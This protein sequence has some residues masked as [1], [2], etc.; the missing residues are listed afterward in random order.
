MVALF[1]GSAM[2]FVLRSDG[3]CFKLVGEIWVPDMM[4]GE[5]YKGLAP[6]YAD[7]EIRLI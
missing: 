7:K 6:K 1:Q 3:H 5:A 2:P 4:H